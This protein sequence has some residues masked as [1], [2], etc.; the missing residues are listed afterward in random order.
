VK[1]PCPPGCIVLNIGE[2]IQ[3]AHRKFF[4]DD[5]KIHVVVESQHDSSSG[6]SD[7][8]PTFGDKD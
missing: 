8:S 5:M 2:R 6:C 1:S 7:N 3:E 4:D